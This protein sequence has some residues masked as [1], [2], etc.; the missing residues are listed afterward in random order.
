KRSG[1]NKRSIVDESNT[2]FVTDVDIGTPPQT[3]SLALRLDTAVIS[4]ADKSCIYL[5]DCPSY[6]K[7]A[8]FCKALCQSVCCDAA[9]QPPSDPSGCD[10]YN[11]ATDCGNRRRFDRSKSSTYLP[12]PD[13]WWGCNGGD[14]TTQFFQGIDTIRVND[15]NGKELA[16]Q[17]ATFGEIYRMTEDDYMLFDGLFGIG[18]SNNTTPTGYTPPLISAHKQGVI[19]DPIVTLWLNR[20]SAETFKA[21][22]TVPSAGKLTVGGLNAQ[23]CGTITEWHPIQPDVWFGDEW[24]GAYDTELRLVLERVCLGNV[25]VDV[26]DENEGPNGASDTSVIVLNRQLVLRW[27]AT[28][29]CIACNATIPP[30]RLQF[31]NTEYLVQPK[32]FI[33][34]LDGL[35]SCSL[36]LGV[37]VSDNPEVSLLPSHCYSIDVDKK[38]MAFAPNLIA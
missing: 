3:F 5:P 12:Y 10:T 38:L 8:L 31:G 33:R 26:Q 9:S 18:V 35:D 13:G 36:K 15:G 28:V 2:Y 14:I 22:T 1:R 29:M 7:A 25:C 20:T 37:I 21:N 11:R 27:I 30:L 19:A 32:D 23:Q 6:C 16:I 4:V 17:N 34:K 24:G